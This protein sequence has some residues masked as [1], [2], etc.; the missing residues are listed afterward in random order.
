MVSH[1]S[2]GH[3]SASSL[4]LF[5]LLQSWHDFWLVFTSQ[6]K[7]AI[8]DLHSS[9]GFG[10]GGVGGAAEQPAGRVNS[11]GS[12]EPGVSAWIW[13]VLVWPHVVILA[14]SGTCVIVSIANMALE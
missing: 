9:L 7:L 5:F 1:S 10:G 12:G 3:P 14:W 8:T 11:E 6:P 4:P 2:C 13:I